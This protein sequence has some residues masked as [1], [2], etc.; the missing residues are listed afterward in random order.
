MDYDIDDWGM[1]KQVEPQ[2]ADLQTH[3][4]VRAFI[5]DTKIGKVFVVV[6]HLGTA[7]QNGIQELIPPSITTMVKGEE[8]HVSV[9]VTEGRRMEAFD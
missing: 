2:L 6:H 8:I 1:F 5:S 9:E 7:I 3:C 4:D